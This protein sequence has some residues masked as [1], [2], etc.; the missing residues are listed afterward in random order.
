M[1]TLVKDDKYV[2]M[3]HL[4]LFVVCSTVQMLLI[5][6]WKFFIKGFRDILFL[7]AW[8]LGLQLVGQLV[9]LPLFLF[10]CNIIC[11]RY[12]S[13]LRRNRYDFVDPSMNQIKVISSG[14]F[15]VNFVKYHDID[16][17]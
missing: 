5:Q 6:T 4:S 16:L 8:L 10:D 15:T 17:D 2:V 13:S 9:S 12:L 11:Y 1:S 14:Y 7:A 3:C